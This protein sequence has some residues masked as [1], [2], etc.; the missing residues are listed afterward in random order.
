[1]GPR[2]GPPFRPP[3]DP[4]E[5]G[6]GFLRVGEDRATGVGQAGRRTPG[7][8]EDREDGGGWSGLVWRGR[9]CGEDWLTRGNAHSN[10]KGFRQMGAAWMALGVI[11]VHDDL[12]LTG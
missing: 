1:M 11:D 10:R 7:Y 3:G 2:A 5:R 8:Q 12:Q 4:P 9:A 6:G